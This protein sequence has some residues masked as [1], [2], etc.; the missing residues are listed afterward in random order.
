MD[1]ILL[2]H[3]LELTQALLLAALDLALVGVFGWGY[4]RTR[5]GYFL[6][7]GASMLAFVYANAL[8]A[9][10]S[11]YGVTHIRLLSGATMRVL[12]LLEAVV[13]PAGSVLW[14]IGAVLLV[15]S[16]VSATPRTRSISAIAEPIQ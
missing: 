5:R 7:L 14:F 11:F 15:R 3:V 4:A 8:S 10:G 9:T 12:F 1:F 13:G 16:V 6:L 2:T